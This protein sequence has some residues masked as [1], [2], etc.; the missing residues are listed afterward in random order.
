MTGIPA[1]IHFWHPRAVKVGRMA[2]PL[3]F[4]VMWGWMVVGLFLPLIGT[5]EGIGPR[6]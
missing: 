1:S 2:I 3:L 5:L 4:W 6:R